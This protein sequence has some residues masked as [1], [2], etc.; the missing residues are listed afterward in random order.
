ML[1]SNPQQGVCQRNDC[2]L[3]KP[4]IIHRIYRIWLEKMVHFGLFLILSWL[5]FIPISYS[6]YA[7]IMYVKY[8]LSITIPKLCIFWRSRFAIVELTACKFLPF[9]HGRFDF[10]CAPIYRI[11]S[12]LIKNVILL[13]CHLYY[14]CSFCW[15]TQWNRYTLVN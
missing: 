1:R 7:S 9:S 5:L 15:S 11:K 12:I 2:C 6:L 3:L 14:F 13:V 4:C 10:W 8:L